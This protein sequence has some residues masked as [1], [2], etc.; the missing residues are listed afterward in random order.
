LREL[1]FGAWDGRTAEACR[2][3]DPNRFDRWMRDPWTTRPPGGESLAQLW[4]RVRG[5][6]S[7]IARKYPGRRVAIVTHGGPIRALLARDPSQ[8]WRAQVPPAALF[9]LLWDPERRPIGA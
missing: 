1:D 3:L 9:N 5:F 8:F 4:K 2:R 6:V 7:S